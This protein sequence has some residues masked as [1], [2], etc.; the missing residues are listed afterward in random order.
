MPKELAIVLNNGTINSAVTTALA[1]QKY[2]PVMA[3][4][5]IEAIEPTPKSRLTYD[6]QVGHFKPFREHIIPVPYFSLLREA[7]FAVGDP[8]ATEPV[9][10][11]LRKL[12][13]LLG[14]AVTLATVY[15]AAAIYIGLR[16]G[17]ATDDLARAVEYMQIWAEMVQ[18]TLGK[19]E[20]EVVAPLVELE[21]W[22]VVDLGFQVGAPLERTWNCIEETGDPCG[23]CRGCRSRDAAFMQAAKPDPSKPAR[24]N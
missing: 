23:T 11:T 10:P 8:R 15:D 16:V 5:E 13:P 2:R 3:F 24:R 17:P 9:E 14:A 18:M 19:P 12:T 1:Q 22:Q 7:A 20:L 21:P 6:L 4:G